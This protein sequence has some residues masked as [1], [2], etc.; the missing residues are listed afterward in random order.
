MTGSPVSP[1][2]K[3]S[4]YLLSRAGL[5]LKIRGRGVLLGYWSGCDGATCH[6]D[7]MGRGRYA[8]LVEEISRL[9]GWQVVRDILSSLY[10]LFHLTVIFSLSLTDDRGGHGVACM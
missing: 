3:F 1:V 10:L 6:I 7:T 9:G 8:S 4:L 5:N 2:Y